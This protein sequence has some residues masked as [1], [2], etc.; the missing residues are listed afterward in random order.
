MQCWPMVV[1][2]GV[3]WQPVVASC[4]MGL[5]LEQVG[6]EGSTW[7]REMWLLGGWDCDLASGM[8]MLGAGMEVDGGL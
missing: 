1:G 2:S 8:V 7:V 4:W 5:G 6:P 3:W